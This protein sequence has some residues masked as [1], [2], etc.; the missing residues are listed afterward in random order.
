MELFLEL[1]PIIIPLIIFD[2]GLRVFAIVDIVKLEKKEINTRWFK[3]VVWIILV[4]IVNL[5]WVIYF[6]AGKEE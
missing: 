1:L 5:A 2:L 4:A 6:I 3:P